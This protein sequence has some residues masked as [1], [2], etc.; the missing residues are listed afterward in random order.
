MKKIG[1]FF[2]VFMTLA[3]VSQGKEPLE[4]QTKQDHSI[5]WDGAVSIQNQHYWRGMQTGRGL[6]FEAGASLSLTDGLTA[7]IW[8]GTALNNSY[9]EIDFYFTYSNKGYSISILDYYCPRNA[10]FS[11]EFGDL[12]EASTPHLVDI[13][14]GYYP[15]HFPFSVMVSTM[16][17]GDDLNEQGKNNYSTYVELA[18][19]NTTDDMTTQLLVGYNLWQSMYSNHAGIVN[20]EA[21]AD[22][23]VAQSG[24]FSI[25]CNTR[26]IYN[27]IR[28]NIYFGAGVSVKRH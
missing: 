26:F 17:W 28:T 7:G 22:Y 20:I 24:S 10:V 16:I 23:R 1:L 2:V 14:A 25:N 13:Q 8:N 19:N 3:M 21:A 15:A 11:K 6:S 18:Y 9:K 12:R 4:E 27:P 5:K